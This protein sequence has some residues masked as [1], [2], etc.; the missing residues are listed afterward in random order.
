MRS[1]SLALAV[2]IR[3]HIIDEFFSGQ[4]SGQDVQKNEIHFWYIFLLRLCLVS[5]ISVTGC[6]PRNTSAWPN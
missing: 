3:W 1:L 4:Q 6:D 2:S 5:I